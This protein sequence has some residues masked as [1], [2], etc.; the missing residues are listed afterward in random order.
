MLFNITDNF[1]D[2]LYEHTGVRLTIEE[3]KQVDEMA[4]DS[5]H[6]SIR[7]NLVST[8]QQD[9]FSNAA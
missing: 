7:D 6:R 1:L 9:L 4:K 8:G 2:T 3:L 5:E